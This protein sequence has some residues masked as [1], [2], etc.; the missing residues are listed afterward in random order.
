M[1][2][3]RDVFDFVCVHAR[4]PVSAERAVKA[5]STRKPQLL[6]RLDDL[7]M[8]DPKETG[9]DILPLGIFADMIVGMIEA[10]YRLIA[11]P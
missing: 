10:A 6:R 5:S 8:R 4:D 2:K 7:A 9:S 3:P 1:L 11:K